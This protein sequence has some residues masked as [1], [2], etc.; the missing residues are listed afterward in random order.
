MAFW[1]NAPFFGNSKGTNE[2]FSSM[3]VQRV[4]APFGMGARRMEQEQENGHE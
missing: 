4:P 3:P 2:P 1:V